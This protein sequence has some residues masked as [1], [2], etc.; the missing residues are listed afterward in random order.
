MCSHE[1][2]VIGSAAI[3]GSRRRA[4]YS[5][6]RSS[7]PVRR[8]QVRSCHSSAALCR[9]DQRRSGNASRAGAGS[10]SQSRPGVARV[11]SQRRPLRRARHAPGLPVRVHQAPRKMELRKRVASDRDGGVL[12]IL[13]LLA[14]FAVR[15]RTAPPARIWRLDHPVQGPGRHPGSAPAVHSGRAYRAHARQVAR[16]RFVAQQAAG[17]RHQGNRQQLLVCSRLAR[18]V[19][20]EQWHCREH[21]S[22]P[23]PPGAHTCR[24]ALFR[25]GLSPRPAIGRVGF[26]ADGHPSPRRRYRAARPHRHYSATQRL[27]KRG[28]R[29]AEGLLEQGWGQ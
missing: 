28:R 26:E 11:A 7:Q 23:Y 27:A 3:A 18:H 6:G 24:S 2:G 17:I 5:T 13:A 1:S 4:Q 12:P 15:A 16:Y 25:P 9:G 19:F 20:H 22:G 10:A 8:L 29:D 14:R 21:R